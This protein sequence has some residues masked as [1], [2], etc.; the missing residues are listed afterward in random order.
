[1]RRETLLERKRFAADL[2]QRDRERVLSGAVLSAPVGS[3][4]RLRRSA[5]RPSI[6]VSK[7]EALVSKP[8][9]DDVLRAYRMRRWWLDNY[10]LDEIRQL[11]EDLQ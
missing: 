9:D 5:E 11:S 3:G 8:T 6:V 1:M 10:T 7:P 4:R 2:A